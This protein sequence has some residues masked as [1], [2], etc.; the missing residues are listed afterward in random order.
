MKKILIILFALFSTSISFADKKVSKKSEGFTRQYGLAGC[1][2]GSVLMGKRSAQIFASTTNG[3]AFNQWFAIS[4]GTLNCVD[5]PSAEVAGR[6][7]QFIMVNRSQ[8]QGDIARGNGETIAALGTFMGCEQLSSKIGNEL[9]S[10][11]SNIFV[12][13]AAANEVTDSVITVILQD[14]ELSKDC[15]HLG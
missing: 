5:S 9:K 13:D 4:A 6:M 12:K 1:G 2:L 11:Y 8:V 7:D 10:H 14:P 3:T 15:K